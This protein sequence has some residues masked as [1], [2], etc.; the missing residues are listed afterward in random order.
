[1][2][3]FDNLPLVKEGESK[4][5]RYLG[6]GEVAIKLKPTVYSYTHNRS[7]VIPGSDTIRYECSRILTGVLFQHGVCHSYQQHRDGLIVS[8]LVYEPQTFVPPDITDAD[9]YSLPHFCPIEVVVKTRHVGTPKHRYFGMGD[10][11]TMYNTYIKSDEAYP[12]WITRFDWR[13]PNIGANGERLCDEV[14]PE[15]LASQY[16]L[17]T[18]ARETATRAFSALSGFLRGRGLRLDDICFFISTQGDVVFSEITPDCM[19][20][21]S[22]D[23]G[24]LDKDVWRAGGSSP[25]LLEKWTRFLELIR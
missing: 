25:R 11:P 14:L 16:I 23:E 18:P 13:N 19:R 21:V 5:V 6:G 20:V 3:D 8:R 24:S 2:T 7:G 22:A 15:D 1:M 12:H 10:T 17:T 9:L 4:I